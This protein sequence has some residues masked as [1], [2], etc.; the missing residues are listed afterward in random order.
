MSRLTRSKDRKVAHVVTPN[1]LQASIA[2]AF[3]L[4][5]GK[6]FSCPN[7]TE[8]C[9]EICY[10]RNIENV[11]KSSHAVVLR[12][13]EFLKDANYA[14]MVELLDEMMAEFK[15]QCDK[16]GAE[17]YF[18]IHWDG[19]FFNATYV[20]AWSKIIAKYSDIQFWVY[21]RVPGAAMF[22]HSR[23]HANLGLYFSADPKNIDVAHGLAAHGV[24]LAYVDSSFA[25]GKRAVPNATRCPENLAA[26]KARAG[27]PNR[28]PLITEKGGACIR[29]NLCVTG[30]GNVLFSTTKK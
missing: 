20:A 6:H 14:E 7:E 22:L 29:C 30:K 26:G 24:N 17:K 11:F 23:K 12:N 28:F 8:F 2:N 15:K 1:G 21:T 9:G 5:A 19:D 18:R 3:G 25:N 16:R 13:W 27:R 10:A 4:P